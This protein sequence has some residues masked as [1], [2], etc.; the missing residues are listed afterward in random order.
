MGS[1]SPRILAMVLDLAR[2]LYLHV[3]DL[4]SVSAKGYG[5]L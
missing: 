2:S 1:S 5:L 4:D 3:C